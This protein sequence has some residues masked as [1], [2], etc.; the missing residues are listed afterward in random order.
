VV[1]VDLNQALADETAQLI[2][3]AGGHAIAV[4]ADVSKAAECEN[5]RGSSY[6]FV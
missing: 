4:K 6:L 5:V 3:A 2:K 1:V